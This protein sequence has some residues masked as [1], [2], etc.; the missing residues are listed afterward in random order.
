MTGNTLREFMDDLLQMGG[1]EKEFTF[2]EK[3][4]FLETTYDRNSEMFKLELVEYNQN[5]ER[6]SQFFGKSF[7]ECVSKFEQSPLFD[8]LTIYEA[9]SEIKVLFG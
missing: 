1:P 8:G 3:K 9:E 5:N 7:S 4:F 2:R 6:V